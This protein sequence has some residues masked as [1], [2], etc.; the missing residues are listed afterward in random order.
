M[1]AK[2]AQKKSPHLT[3]SFPATFFKDIHHLYIQALQ[4]S[5]LALAL[6]VKEL[7]FKVMTFLLLPRTQDLS[8]KNMSSDDLNLWINTLKN[9]ID[10]DFFS[11]I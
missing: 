7:E 6:K 10:E 3:D 2:R 1:P 8:F 9:E 4:D 11:V 5:Q